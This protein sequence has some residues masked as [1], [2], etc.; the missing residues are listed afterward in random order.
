MNEPRRRPPLHRP[1]RPRGLDVTN[2]CLL[3]AAVLA[4]LPWLFAPGTSAQPTPRA[5]VKAVS[6]LHIN[7][8]M[9]H[10]VST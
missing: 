1:R 4:T 10:G 8:A 7:V 5:A 9:N 2:L 3:I 6:V